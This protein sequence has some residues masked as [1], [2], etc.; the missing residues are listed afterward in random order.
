MRRKSVVEWNAFSHILPNPR[1][2]SSGI[3][4]R[5]EKLGLSNSGLGLKPDL[6]SL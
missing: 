2:L 6:L 3:L 1:L 4:Q 5:D